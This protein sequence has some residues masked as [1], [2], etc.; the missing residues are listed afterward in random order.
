MK[1]T[2]EIRRARA[3]FFFLSTVTVSALA[4][5]SRVGSSRAVSR[6][7]AALRAWLAWCAETGAIKSLPRFPKRL[8][9]PQ[10]PP[11]S[12]ERVDEN[13]LLR[14]I[15]RQGSDR[16][17]ALVGLMLFA[18]LRVGEAVKLKVGDVEIKERR[19]KVVVAYG[20]G[21]KWRDVPLSA[22]ARA[23]VGPWLKKQKALGA[24]AWL[25]P[26]RTASGNL[27]VRAAQ[28][29]VK[30]Y[31]NLGRPGEQA[32]AHAL[33]HTFA[34][35]LVRAG[36][37]LDVAAQIVGHARV[38]TAAKYTRARWVELEEAVERR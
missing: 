10:R 8:A 29:V 31:V 13:R 22:Q 34:T 9:E 32:A 18:G 7:L 20:R 1:L 16:D 28:D 33:R 3:A 23:L 36:V 17:R 26:V 25:F 6:G 4:T 35:R 24:H 21:M 5:I 15:E 19:G 2:R 30:K 12:L 11:R 27:T 37:G 38:E 14:A